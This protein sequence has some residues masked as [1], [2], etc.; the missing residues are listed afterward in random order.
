MAAPKKKIFHSE[1]N[2]NLRK[3][4]NLENDKELQALFLSYANL[5]DEELL[6]NLKLTSLELDAK[7]Q[8]ANPSSWL[9]FLKYPIVKRYIDNYLDEDAEKKAQLVLA[10]DAGKARDAIQIQKNI[11]EKNKKNDNSNIV[12]LFMPQKSYVE[13]V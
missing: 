1:L 12:V 9:K 8:T 13:N 5:Y 3:D 10:Q 11:Q 4:R 2:L 6:D 7:Y